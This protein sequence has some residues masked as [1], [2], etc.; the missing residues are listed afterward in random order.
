MKNAF[1]FCVMLLSATSAFA[2]SA[3]DVLNFTLPELD[4]AGQKQAS[5]WATW[6]FLPQMDASTSGHSLIKPDGSAFSVKLSHHSFCVA[7]MEGSVRIRQG[8]GNTV[9][10][11]AGK[12]DS[13]PDCSDIYPKFPKTGFIHWRVAHGSFGDGADREEGQ[14]PWILIPYRSIAVDPKVIPFGSAVYI[15]AARGTR[16]TLPSGTSVL[17][18]G[19]FVATDRGGGILDNHIDVYVGTSET[20]PFK[21]VKSSESA[22]FTAYILSSGSAQQALA[23]ASTI[24]K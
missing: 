1:A 13:G 24:S 20:N 10:N 22:T 5:L 14:L 4:S 11:W 3:S 12:A 18:D 6:Y 8:S 19:Y 23:K 2:D 9:Y 15:P 7:A 16:I 17:H 21:F